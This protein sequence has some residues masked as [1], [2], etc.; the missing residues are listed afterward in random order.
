MKKALRFTLLELLVVVAVISILMSLLLPALGA[1]KGSA[2]S[3]QCTG[4]LKQFVTAAL[5]YESNYGNWFLPVHYWS[6][7]A[8]SGFGSAWYANPE[9]T[10]VLG[11]KNTWTWKPSLMCPD[12]TTA[13]SKANPAYSYGMNYNNFISTWSTTEYH[14]HYTPQI[15][16]PSSKLVFVDNWGWLACWNNSDP[17]QNGNAYWRWFEVDDAGRE[18][19]V[20]YRHSHFKSANVAFFDGHATNIL[21]D[22]ACSTQSYYSMW[23][24]KTN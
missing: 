8:H 19:G 18:G 23:N 9:F 15:V 10:S 3:L 13:V 12:A 7:T 6:D 2:R 24:I 20:A 11:L 22:K 21:W 1:A 17:R 4:N 5:V 14:G 16:N